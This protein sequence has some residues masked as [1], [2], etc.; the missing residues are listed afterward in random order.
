MFTFID[1]RK[2]PKY[3]QNSLLT[4]IRVIVDSDCEAGPEV[5]ALSGRHLASLATLPD[6]LPVLQGLIEKMSAAEKEELKK[7]VH[8]SA[9]GINTSNHTH[10]YL[11]IN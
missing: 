5:K 8:E 6:I 1:I 10:C 7:Y 4:C 2:D 11:V 9:D 3:I